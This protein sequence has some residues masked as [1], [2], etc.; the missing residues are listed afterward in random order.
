MGGCPDPSPKYV[1][2]GIGDGWPKLRVSAL[3]PPRR[4]RRGV[5][6]AEVMVTQGDVGTELCAQAES[7]GDG[8]YSGAS[9]MLGAHL[10]AAA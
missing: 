4:R 10:G 1:V 6:C 9:L 5:V 2:P 8:T 7:G 3:G